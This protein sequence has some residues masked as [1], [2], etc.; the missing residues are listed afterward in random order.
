MISARNFL[1]FAP[2]VALAAAA[3]LFTAASAVA[4]TDA[5]PSWNNTAPKQAI[6]SFVEK[7]TKPGSARI[8][9]GSGAHRRVRQ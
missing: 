8:R 1:Y 4:Q 7:V 3:C 5:L 9:A 6:I 2:G